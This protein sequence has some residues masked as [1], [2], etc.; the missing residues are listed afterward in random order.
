MSI[1][2]VRRI[3][4]RLLPYVEEEGHREVAQLL[5]NGPDNQER[6]LQLEVERDQAFRITIT[7][8]FVR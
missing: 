6:R 5:E 4:E 2:D 8:G 1:Q 7:A 3:V